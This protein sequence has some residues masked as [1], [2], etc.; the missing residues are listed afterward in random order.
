MKFG[1]PKKVIK[2]WREFGNSSKS[3]FRKKVISSETG[4]RQSNI[5]LLIAK[6]DAE[7]LPEW[8][9]GKWNRDDIMRKFIKLS[10]FSKAITA[11]KMKFS[12][13]DFFSKCDQICS[14]LRISLH[15]LNNSLMENLIFCAVYYG[16]NSINFQKTC[17][18]FCLE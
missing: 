10:H 8:G 17:G 4:R 14:F 3:V 6:P 9:K 11:H 12:I 2:R 7:F 13:K 5:R 16:E 1:K 18:L 15:C